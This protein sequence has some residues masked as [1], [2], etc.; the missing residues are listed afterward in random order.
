LERGRSDDRNNPLKKGQ[1]LEAS[2][3]IFFFPNNC[4]ADFTKNYFSRCPIFYELAMQ[5]RPIDKELI[6]GFR[7]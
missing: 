7:K 3:I 2:P 6:H 4:R 5:E 1:S